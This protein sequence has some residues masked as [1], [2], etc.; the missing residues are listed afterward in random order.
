M[1]V[2]DAIAAIP[3]LIWAIAVVGISGWTAIRL[4]PFTLAN[5]IKV[6]V[7]LGR[8]LH[9]RAGAPH[10][11]PAAKAES[12]SDYVDARRLQGAAEWR[13][14]VWRRA[15]ELPVAGHRAGD[16]A[17]W[18]SASSS[19]RRSASSASACSRRPRAGAPC[20]PRRATTCSPAMVAVGVPG[21]CDLAHGDRLQPAG[22]R[23]ARRARPAPQHR[24][25]DG[26]TLPLM[27][28]GRAADRVRPR[29]EVVRGVDLAIAPGE[30]VGLVGESGS[31]KSMTALGHHAAAAARRAH[32]RRRY[33]ACRDRSLLAVIGAR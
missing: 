20:W 8:A 13:I 19:R 29:S 10:H 15:A 31:G 21:S 17:A 16:A 23:A 18:P 28:S 4:G 25:A 1:R 30:A 6:M 3:L 11:M 14:M 33:P 2:L 5:E 7:L 22:R 12:R 24:G 9:P 27:Q 26:M 32:R